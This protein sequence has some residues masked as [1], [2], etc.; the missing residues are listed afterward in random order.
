MRYPSKDNEFHINA[1]R[2]QYWLYAMLNKKF[3]SEVKFHRDSLHSRY[4]VNRHG[5]EISTNTLPIAEVKKWLLENL[6][7]SGFIKDPNWSE[8]VVKK[9]ERNTGFE[10][11]AITFHEQSCGTDY[12]NRDKPV[13]IVNGMVYWKRKK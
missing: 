9:T 11:L 6:S 13:I 12:K 4:Q 5:F 2:L 10:E 3:G 7:N 1:Y 8:C